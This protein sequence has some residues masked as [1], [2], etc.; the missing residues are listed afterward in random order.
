MSPLLLVPFSLQCQRIPLPPRGSRSPLAF[1]LRAFHMV[2]GD[3]STSDD[4]A[5]RHHLTHRPPITFPVN[6]GDLLLNLMMLSC[7]SPPSPLLK[8][9]HAQLGH[10]S[11]KI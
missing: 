7:K 2:M 3:L 9:Y 5:T 10:N 4:L 6:L 8:P 1:L 11:A